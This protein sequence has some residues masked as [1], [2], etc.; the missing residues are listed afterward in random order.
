MSDNPPVPP[1]PLHAALM[2]HTGFLISRMGMVAQKQFAER[3]ESLGLTPRMWGALNV[4]DA[5]GAITQHALGKSVGIDPSSMVSTIDELERQG[6]VERRRHP[7]DRR[8]HALHVTT[9]GKRT[10]ARGRELAKQSQAELL[11]PLNAEEREQLHALLLRLAI[12]SAGVGK[13][14]PPPGVGKEGPPASSKT[15]TATG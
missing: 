7:S 2:R 9:L 3:M 10:L 1:P 13:E 12:H 4:L 6:L 15:H 14:G 5:E 11:E 8:A